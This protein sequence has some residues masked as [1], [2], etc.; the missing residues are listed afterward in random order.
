ME[1]PVESPAESPVGSHPHA[2]PPD[3]TYPA[4]GASAGPQDQPG[5]GPDHPPGTGP[6]RGCRELDE[7]AARR[8]SEGRLRDQ[9]ADERDGTAQHLDRVTQLWEAF[10]CAPGQVEQVPE[11]VMAPD[12]LQ[13]LRQVS[14]QNRRRAAQDRR[15]AAAERRVAA[16]DRDLAGA[17]RRARAGE[18]AGAAVDGLTGV[19]RRDSGFARLTQ[20]LAR[21][22]RNHQSLAVAFVDVDGLKATND[23]YGHLAGDRRLRAVAE[24]LKAHLRPYD[25]V[26]R[27]GGDEFVCVLTGLTSLEL[28]KRFGSV[29]QVLADAHQSGPVTV[30]LADLQPGDAPTDVIAR[31]DRALYQQRASRTA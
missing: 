30:G 25:L 18:R 12:L 10:L 15:A 13:R 29:N 4:D 3:P 26:F 20:E 5:T 9:A 27:Y 21:A 16:A 1:F 24:V 14:A 31:A 6:D 17:E 22:N 8:D 28:A 19:Y 2:C 23:R 11:G 7:A